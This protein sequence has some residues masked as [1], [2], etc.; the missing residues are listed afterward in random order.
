MNLSDLKFSVRD[1]VT[2]KGKISRIQFLIW[3]GVLFAVKYNLDRLL[4][5]WVSGR[6]WSIFN[7]FDQPMPGFQSL[8]PAQNSKELVALLLASSPFLWCGL[9]LCV[10]RLRSAGLPL[11]LSALFVVPILKWFL[12]VSLALV[13]EREAKSEQRGSGGAW[14]P[15][16]MVGSAALAIGITVVFAVI[17][18][19]LSTSLL[20]KYGWGLFAGVPFC[21]GFFSALIHGARQPRRLSESILVAIVSLIIAGTLLLLVAMEGIICLLMAAPLA[22]GLALI[23]A[24]VGHLIQASRLGSVPPQVFCIP[25][26]STPLMLGSEVAR[27]TPP[28]L[29]QVVSSIE[30]D[31]P[32]ETV[33]RH[34]IA[35]ANLPPPKEL[36]FRLGVAYP[37]RAEI[38]GH[39]PGAVRNCVFS[40]GAFVEPI[41]VWAEPELLKF[42]VTTN[43]A[44]LQEWTPYGQIH[45]PHLKG[46]LVSEKGQFR[47]IRLPSGHTRLEGTTW[48]HHGMWPVGYW[49]T[50]SD[51]IIHSIHLRVLNHIKKSAEADAE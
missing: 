42:S 45:P 30:V 27:P 7:Y 44:P 47:L 38:Q 41:E 24:L 34:V 28:P 19:W 17:A 25:F 22:L 51:H 33:W 37:I 23:G 13:P 49:Q 12:F 6:Q 10:K 21:M 3:A 11:A 35:F 31:A 32:P 48:Y 4:L 14:L 16:S 15:S 43:P 36:L 26:M 1:V 2:W 50:W 8:S 5:Y 9:V 18:A 39:G 20:R 29:L 46:F 40:T